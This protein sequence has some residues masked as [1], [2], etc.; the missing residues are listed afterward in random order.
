MPWR[1]KVD[2]TNPSSV[3]QF[4]DERSEQSYTFI[5]GRRD[6]AQYRFGR[7]K[8]S[9]DRIH[10]FGGDFI[11]EDY[12]IPELHMPSYQRE[13]ELLR[14]AVDRKVEVRILAKWDPSS[15]QLI[16]MI[17]R[18]VDQKIDIRKWAGEIRGGI[19][20]DEVYVIKR[21]IAIPPSELTIEV[22]ENLPPKTVAEPQSDKDVPLE[23]IATKFPFVVDSFEKVFW[24]EYKK[25][26]PMK[27]ELQDLERSVSDFRSNGSS[28]DSF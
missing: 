17:K 4:M 13:M 8:V 11:A 27:D 12:K 20:D 1:E 22:A 26:N 2:W 18:Y 16:S 28:R 7:E 19:I 23:A 24:E 9:R 14:R 15:P 5:S 10:L 3:Q 21:H 6:L 25:A